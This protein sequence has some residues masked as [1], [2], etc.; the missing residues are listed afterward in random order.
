MAR[1]TSYLSCDILVLQSPGDQ[2]DYEPLVRRQ[3]TSS[4][5]VGHAVGLYF[6]EPWVSIKRG[7]FTGDANHKIQRANRGFL[8]RTM[9]RI[10]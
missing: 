6:A 3:G 9:G 4:I 2:R 10:L 5:E 8:K 1:R 7:R